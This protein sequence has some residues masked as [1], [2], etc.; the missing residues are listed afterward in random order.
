V[1][2]LYRERGR[3]GSELLNRGIEDVQLT[4]DIGQPLP[5]SVY[6]ADS[7]TAA[8]APGCTNAADGGVALWSFGACPGVLGAPSHTATLDGGVYPDWRNDSYDTASRYLGHPM[9]IRNV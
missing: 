4:Y 8:A 1:P 5:P 3:G 6:A 2:S 9:N 7:G